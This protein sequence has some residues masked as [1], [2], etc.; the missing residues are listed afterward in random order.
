MVLADEETKYS[1]PIFAECYVMSN[2]QLIKLM[3]PRK[4]F[5]WIYTLTLFIYFSVISWNWTT[6]Q[7]EHPACSSS[8]KQINSNDLHL[9]TISLRHLIPG[10]LLIFNTVLK[11]NRYSLNMQ[12]KVNLNNCWKKKSY[13][14]SRVF[15]FV[16]FLL[17]NCFGVLLKRNTWKHSC[18]IELN[19]S[20]GLYLK[21]SHT[22]IFQAR[23]AIF[24][25]PHSLEQVWERKVELLY[26]LT[27]DLSNRLIAAF[28]RIRRWNWE[29]SESCETQVL[30]K[31]MWVPYWDSFCPCSTTVL[32]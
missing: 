17:V 23:L 4:W 26:N 30:E 25:P 5:I 32:S 2:Y 13:N 18:F 11:P 16:C 20:V 29:Y 10:C 27:A 1:I 28:S 19:N 6:L 7:Q 12:L 22:G 3:K 24:L 9:L 8:K 21:R 31:P 14:W 15:L